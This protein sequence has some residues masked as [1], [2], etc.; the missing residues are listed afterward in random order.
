MHGATTNFTPK[1]QM[2]IGHLNV[3]RDSIILMQTSNANH[4]QEQTSFEGI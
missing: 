3:R 2:A 4:V 1:L